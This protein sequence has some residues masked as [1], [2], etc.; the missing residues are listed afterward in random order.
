M[1]TIEKAVELCDAAMNRDPRKFPYGYFAG[2]SAGIDTARVFMW[3]ASEADLI[4]HIIE[5]EPPVYELDSDEA[6]LFAQ[7]TCSDL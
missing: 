1:I 7:N 2:G 4:S 5:C 3:F 6:S